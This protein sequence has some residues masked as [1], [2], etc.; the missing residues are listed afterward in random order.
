MGRLHKVSRLS[1]QDW[2][3]LVQAW[4]LLLFLDIALRLLP[5][6]SVLARCDRSRCRQAPAGG[7]PPSAER[8]AWLVELA[9]RCHLIRSTCL[10][11]ALA[12]S[13][14]LKRLGMR[15]T[16]RIGVSRETG[17]FQAHAWLEEGD[18]IIFGSQEGRTYEPLLP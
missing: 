15:T 14:L 3:I 4:T 18:R 10:K 2:T 9:G 1:R 16:L 12:L 11:Q 7:R 5:F 17:D 8:C 6:R 13:F